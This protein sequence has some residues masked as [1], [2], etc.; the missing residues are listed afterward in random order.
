MYVGSGE[1]ES[2]ASKFTVSP[3]LISCKS[4]LTRAFG[5]V[6]LSPEQPTKLA[7]SIIKTSATGKHFRVDVMLDLHNCPLIGVLQY[8]VTV[9]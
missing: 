8:S 1:D 2:L 4:A 6:E 5:V 9:L 3:T 7:E